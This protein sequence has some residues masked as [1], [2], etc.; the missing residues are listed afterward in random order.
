[1]RNSSTTVLP[2]TSRP[3][4]MADSTSATS[5]PMSTTYL[6]RGTM[7]VI[8]SS[9]LA[10]LSMASVASMPRAMELVSSMAMAGPKVSALFMP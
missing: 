4:R 1:M 5:P 8:R 9:T 6:P 3:A 7:V 10:R 2:A